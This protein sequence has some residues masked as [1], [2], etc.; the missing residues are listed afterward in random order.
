MKLAP[1]VK[2]QSRGIKHKG[3]EVIIFAGSDAWAHAKQWQEH[4]AR[5]AGDN[6][7]PVWLG[8]QQ[9]S[10]LDNL[11]IVPEGRKSARIYRAGYLAPVMIKAI[12]QKL[13][14]AGVQDANF[15]PEGMHGQEVQNWREYL[16][17]ERQ[18]LSDGLVIELPVKQKAQL[19]QMADSERAQLLADRFDGVC[20]HPESEIVHVWRGGVWCP[21]S[22][23]EL[24]REMVAIYSEHRAT[25][26][27]RVINNAVEALKVIAEPM[28]EPSGDLLP[29]ANGALDLK[30]GEFSP[31][32]PE[33]WITTHN[34]IEYTPPA[35][36]ENIR[37]NAPNFH[38]WLEHAAG[39]DPRKMMRIC[40]AL[41]MIMANRYDWQ[42]FI[43]ATGDGGSGKSTFTHIAS[44]LAGKQNTVSAE[45]TSLDDAGGRAQVVGS[46][47]IVLADQP[48]YTGE[49]TGIKKIT[50]GD[51]VEINPK[52]EKRFT[53]VIRAVVLAT[54]NNPM[55]FTE[56]AGGVARRRV[57]FRFDNI[58]REDEKDKELPE[59]IA[60]EIPVI[61]RRLLAN[62][63]DPEKAR[64]LLLEQRDGDEALAIKQQTDPVVELCAAL[65]FL[66]EARGLMMGGG[67]DTVK[68][69]T[70]NSLYR[71]YMAFMAYTGKGKCL[72]VNEFG[73][74]MRSAAKV[75]G[76]EY[77]TRKVKGVTQTNATTTDD[78]DAFL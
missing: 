9:L 14:A 77:I 65:E 61:I 46:R 72:S 34:G 42:M 37:D 66:E 19:S 7:P 56:R 5:M 13:A 38:K 11:Q 20:V 63:A 36:G 29:F 45:M 31:H 32:T 1:N 21:V 49:G 12:G 25:F 26:S 39:K 30:T 76:Y 53:A 22:T 48:K 62:F 73:K 35:P 69:T 55:I 23:M 27:K 70:R 47:L 50:G 52:Y 78:C 4:D 8:E 54:N 74:A 10:E 6:E 41:Y 3:T 71:V 28:G 59:K 24:S 58:V 51:P 40:A 16:A 43:E 17:R 33:D 57:I 18:N 60:A 67:G 64:A 75:Y 44:L 2:Q 68:Y 15:Y